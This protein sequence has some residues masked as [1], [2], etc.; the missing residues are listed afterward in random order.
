MRLLLEGLQMMICA[1]CSSMLGFARAS[2]SWK[3]H[4]S[5]LVSQPHR[6]VLRKSFKMLVMARLNCSEYAGLICHWIRIALGCKIMFHGKP[7]RALRLTSQSSELCCNDGQEHPSKDILK[8]ML[9]DG[10]VEAQMPADE[11]SL[12][13]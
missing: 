12:E 2:K 3:N 8:P 7:W 11:G 13:A 6:I 10:C 9:L 4:Q 1:H 5:R